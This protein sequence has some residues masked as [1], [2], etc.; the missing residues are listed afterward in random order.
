[1]LLLWK[2]MSGHI[3]QHA[4]MAGTSSESLLRGCSQSSTLGA[5][6]CGQMWPWVGTAILCMA[7]G[8]MH[9]QGPPGFLFLWFPSSNWAVSHPDFHYVRNIISNRSFPSATETAF[10][11][12]YLRFETGWFHSVCFHS[13]TPVTKLRKV[14]A[15]WCQ[16]I[17]FS[18]QRMS[19]VFS[20]QRCVSCKLVMLIYK[21]LHGLRP[22]GETVLIT[23]YCCC[24]TDCGAGFHPASRRAFCHYSSALW[25]S[26]C[27][28]SHHC[29]EALKEMEV[30]VLVEPPD[31][32]SEF[33]SLLSVAGDPSDV[34]QQFPQMFQNCL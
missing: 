7:E 17:S 19:L 26:L 12:C 10:N 21:A 14:Q 32:S 22:P 29:T 13:V 8:G 24:L 9:V 6:P 1:M 31:T 15:D 34:K 4:A 2:L 23:T 30:W 3:C 27:D 16:K 25:N 18:E 20:V 28:E 5:G 33:H 11:S